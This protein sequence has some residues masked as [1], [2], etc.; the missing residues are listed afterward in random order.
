MCLLIIPSTTCLQLMALTTLLVNYLQ[1]SAFLFGLEHFPNNT[2]KR[3]EAISIYLGLLQPSVSEES[4][5]R[6]MECFTIECSHSLGNSKGKK[7]KRQ[8]SGTPNDCK[9]L[10]HIITCNHSHVL[11]CIKQQ[12]RPLYSTPDRTSPLKPLVLTPPVQSCCS[13][14]VRLTYRSS[15]PIVYTTRGTYIA[16]SYHGNCTKC[17]VY[18][19]SH[20]E[21]SA[22][23]IVFYSNPE[24]QYLQISSQ[25]AFET[26]YLRTI[27]HS[28]CICST[29]FEALA[30]LYTANNMLNDKERLDKLELFARSS[31]ERPWTLNPQRLEEGWFIYNLITF[32]KKWSNPSVNLYTP[33]TNGRKNLEKLCEHAID[34]L[35]VEPPPWINHSCK[36][37]GC[38]ARYAT[39]DGNAKITRTMCAAPRSQVQIP[40]GRISVMSCCPNTPSLGGFHCSGSKYCDRHSYLA[41]PQD[42]TSPHL[43][44]DLSS[45]PQ[46][47]GLALWP[48][49]SIHNNTDLDSQEGSNGCRK[50]ENVQKFYNRTA[51]LAALV[52]PCGIVINWTEMFTSESLTQMYLFLIFTFGRGKDIEHLRYLGFDRAC[53]LEPFLQNL[54][55]KDVMFAKYLLRH[56]KFLVDRFHVKGHTANC[57]TPL[58]DNPLCK[59]HPGLEQ[60][61]E[62]RD[63]NTECAEQAF[64]WMNKLRYGARQM[65]RYKFNFYLHIMICTHNTL[66]EQHLTSIGKM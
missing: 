33:M 51:G 32:Y 53:G 19:P 9:D 37:P 56:V 49:A 66:R 1:L 46:N 58:E 61:K 48:P 63:A 21:P 55:K 50:P 11:E 5:Q 6:I 17:P 2:P 40:A 41:M 54:A 45:D 20:Y 39:L 23:T 7:K 3:W 47:Q 35:C 10:E 65:S 31:R 26:E 15:F 43:N 24:V 34:I 4:E 27:T 64:K 42:T 44:H 38:A 14:A 52:R 13:L 28:L 25:T 59:Y 29:T 16:A 57:C 36:I 18:Y 62:V 30:A 60:F 8:F 12:Y 22:N